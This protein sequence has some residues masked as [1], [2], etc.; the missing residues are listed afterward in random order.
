MVQSY[1]TERLKFLGTHV[2]PEMTL[3]ERKSTDLCN[4]GFKGRWELKTFNE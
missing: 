3:G 2:V 4:G 1:L